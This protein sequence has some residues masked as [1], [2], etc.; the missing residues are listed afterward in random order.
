MDTYAEICDDGGTLNR[1]PT[2]IRPEGPE[3]YETPGPHPPGALVET[4]LPYL[5][6]PR[7]LA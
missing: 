1:A 6:R 2:V 7:Q 4:G 3:G 5:S